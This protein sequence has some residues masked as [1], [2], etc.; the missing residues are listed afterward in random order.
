MF[1]AVDKVG[2]ATLAILDHKLL[3][4]GTSGVQMASKK[5]SVSFGQF[6][7]Q[8]VAYFRAA[9]L[10]KSRPLGQA[11]S[12]GRSLI[13]ACLIYGQTKYLLELVVISEAA[14]S[15]PWWAS[16]FSI[17]FFVRVCIRQVI[18]FKAGHC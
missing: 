2:L 8:G 5:K 3:V 9:M 14:A 15:C 13:T 1:L 4:V 18:V 11:F 12:C 17:R 10:S 6:I 7:I 16:I